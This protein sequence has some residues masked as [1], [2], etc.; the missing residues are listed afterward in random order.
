[1]RT[2]GIVVVGASAGG[3]EA[4]RN[5]VAGLSPEFPLPVCVALH[6]SPHSRGLLGEILDRSG[7]LRANNARGFERLRPGRIY[8]A[9]PDRHL[10]VGPGV[11]R[12]TTGSRENGFR[13]AID[14]LFRSTAQVY[15]PEAIGVVLSGNLHD[16]TRG[17]GAIK[18]LG[19]VAIVHDPS[20]AL[21]PSMPRNALQH[22]NVDH[23]VRLSDMASLLN[24]L[25]TT[26]T[27]AASAAGHEV[28]NG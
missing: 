7:P 19:G 2:G 1:M 18:D 12:L 13:P 9:P 4:L 28:D 22:V 21:F 20:D 17:L 26:E 11:V 15:G 14:P 5:L 25:A 8:V 23:C 24:R 16:G 10:I 3:I 6:V 27:E